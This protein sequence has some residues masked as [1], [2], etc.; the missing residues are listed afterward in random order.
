MKINNIKKVS[1][2]L[3]RFDF[4]RDSHSTSLRTICRTNEDELRNVEICSFNNFGLSCSQKQRA[5]EREIA[6]IISNSINSF[7]NVLSSDITEITI[8][9]FEI[10][11]YFEEGSINPIMC[12]AVFSVKEERCIEIKVCRECESGSYYSD[13]FFD[14]ES[15]S[16]GEEEQINSIDDVAKALG[17]HAPFYSPET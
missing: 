9:N 14:Y 13:A 17:K 11:I 6:R 16:L 2:I 5:Q 8:Q 4:G 3:A 1:K 15:I 12:S 10:I 7:C